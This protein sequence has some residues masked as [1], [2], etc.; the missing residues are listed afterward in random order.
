MRYAKNV[1]LIRLV[2]LM[3]H[4]ANALIIARNVMIVSSV[5]VVRRSI[6]SQ[7]VKRL[8]LSVRKTAWNAITPKHVTFAKTGTTGTKKSL[9]A[10]PAKMVVVNAAKTHALSVS[11]NSTSTKIPR[12]AFTALPNVRSANLKTFASN[13]TKATI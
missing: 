4:V 2:K 1:K 13:A 7:K 3:A 8:V 12:A 5:T 10:S 6:S 9:N 11:K